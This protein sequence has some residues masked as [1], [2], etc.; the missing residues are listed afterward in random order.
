MDSLRGAIAAAVTP[1]REGGQH[2]DEETFAPLVRFLAD[3]GVD[4]LLA[5]GT[6]GEGVLLSVDERRRV[7]ELFLAA[8]PDGFQIA[9]HAGAQTTADTI[10]LAAHALEAGADAVAVIAPPYYPL[11]DDEL[12]Q[13]FVQAANG[14]DPLPF[15]LYEFIGRSGYAIP[16][17]V[18]ARVRDNA[19]NLRGLKVSDTPFAAI[20]PYL[21]V[22][23][24]DVFIGSEPLVLE[25]MARGAVGAVSGLATAFPEIVSALVHETDA[26]ANEQVGVLRAGLQGIPF[27]AALKEIL[28]QQDVLTSADVRAPLRGLTDNERS[29]VLGLARDVGDR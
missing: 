6:T 17:E 20:E 26:R 28:V 14:C 7:T 25:G 27:H 24:M 23:G 18:I 22:E 29:T 3:G 5:C 9:V 16:I 21:D 1:L 15:Y 11:D 19:P 2:L 10:A 13:H 4:G 8:R 12:T